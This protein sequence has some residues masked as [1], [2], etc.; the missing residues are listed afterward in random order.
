LAE[1]RDEME[2]YDFENDPGEFN[3]L[4]LDSSHDSLVRQLASE[5]MRYRSQMDRD[6]PNR[7][8]GA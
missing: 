2:L 6:W 5:M 3:N 7:G 4:A 1:A 8:A